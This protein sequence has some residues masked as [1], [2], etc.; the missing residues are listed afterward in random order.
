M[1][2][3]KPSEWEDEFEYDVDCEEVA[4]QLDEDAEYIESIT[5]SMDGY[6]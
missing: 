5:K 6:T 4:R 1:K 2:P 3:K